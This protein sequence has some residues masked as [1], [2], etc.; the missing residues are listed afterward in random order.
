M[1]KKNS[2]KTATKEALQASEP[3]LQQFSNWRGISFEL[4][5]HAWSDSPY[6][7]T[8]PSEWPGGDHHNQSDL[9]ANTFMVQN[10]I[11]IC[12]NGS[13]E[14]RNEAAA[15]GHKENLYGAD[16][17]QDP[18]DFTGISHMVSGE[19][20]VATYNGQ[21]QHISIGDFLNIQRRENV[22]EKESGPDSDFIKD[23][24]CSSSFDLENS[25]IANNV[26]FPTENALKFITI[27]FAPE[28]PEQ[29]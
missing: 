11:N 17:Y 29:D 5:P 15:I 7:A 4:A 9:P 20:Y 10:N 25:V 13:I 24:I 14:T 18:G 6:N 22:A 21:I 3:R 2:T 16:I 12:S 1:A 19:L 8:D 28:L 26:G 27:T 23:V